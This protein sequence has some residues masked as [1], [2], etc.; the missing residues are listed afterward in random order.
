[1]QLRPGLLNSLHILRVD[2]E[3]ESLGSSVVVSPKGTD[4]VLS[5]NVLFAS[6]LISACSLAADHWHAHPDVESVQR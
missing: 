3:Y 1:V 5:S 4:F 6:I 2:D